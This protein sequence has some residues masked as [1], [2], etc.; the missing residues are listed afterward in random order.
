MNKF[1]G[2]F[3]AVCIAGVMTASLCALA[4]CQGN[5]QEQSIGVTGVTISGSD[6]ELNVEQTSQLTATVE[7]ENA[8]NKNV[9]WESDDTSVATV[10]ES[11]LV[12]AVSEGVAIITVTTKDGGFEDSVGVTV[13]VP[14]V[15]ANELFTLTDGESSI[16]FFD[17]KTFELNG[18]SSLGDTPLPLSEPVTG[19]YTVTETAISLVPS[20]KVN[21]EFMG[22]EMQFDLLQSF[23][24]TEDGGVLKAYVNNGTSDFVIGEFVFTTDQL[25]SLGLNT[26]AAYAV[27]TATREANVLVPAP[28]DTITFMSDNTVTIHAEDAANLLPGIAPSGDYKTTWSVKD[29]VLTIAETTSDNTKISATVTQTGKGL[30]IQV[31]ANTSDL[32]EFLI[33]IEDAAKLGVTIEIVHVTSV[34]LSESTKAMISGNALDVSTLVQMQPANASF[35]GSDITLS[36][37]TPSDAVTLSGSTVTAYR[38]GTATVVVTVDGQSAELTVNVSYPEKSDSFAEYAEAVCF[39]QTTVFAGTLVNSGLSLSYTLMFE[40]DGM[41]S[42]RMEVAGQALN[43]LG[44]YTLVKS[45]DAIQS[46]KI[47]L[48]GDPVQEHTLTYSNTGGTETLTCATLGEGTLTKSS[49]A[50]E[51]ET[52]FQYKLSLGDYGTATLEF[53]FKPDGTY[54]YRNEAF[55]QT[56]SESG[57]Y[58]YI[59]S[60]GMLTTT[61]TEGKDS[62]I[63]ATVTETDGIRSFVV[64]D[65]TLTEV[66]D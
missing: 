48:F 33:P 64:N 37:K 15:P 45:G 61:V 30:A 13:S 46:I 7:P 66:T 32:T 24:L 60:T 21:V 11:G 9:E 31:K 3:S 26:D 16:K 49:T 4:A 14:K 52:T 28:K 36:L 1:W 43:S 40:T 55:G 23:N 34:T 17:D 2:K 44:Y 53:T 18:Q 51:K 57:T 65:A 35:D 38:E 12:T 20:G 10:S 29:N 8:T 5:P 22:M 59:A 19:T 6:L 41:L 54:T 39:D 63:S 47:A 27:V 56:V 62:A 25:K 42:L 58:V 50:F